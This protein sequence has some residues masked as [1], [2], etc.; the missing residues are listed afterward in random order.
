ME[1]IASISFISTNDGK[2]FTRVPA[3]FRVRLSDVFRVRFNHL[4]KFKML[5]FKN[6]N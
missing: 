1:Y 2:I 4:K 3:N 6:L 5:I